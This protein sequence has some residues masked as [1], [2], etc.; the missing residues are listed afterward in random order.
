VDAPAAG[1][2]DGPEGGGEDR[3]STRADGSACGDRG[4]EQPPVT[5]TAATITHR[6]APAARD[7][8][9]IFSTDAFLSVMQSV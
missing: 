6:P 1:D 3:P 7:L 4:D 8:L 9:A 2:V 5:T